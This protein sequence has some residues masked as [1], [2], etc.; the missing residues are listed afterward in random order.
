MLR[1]NGMTSVFLAKGYQGDTLTQRALWRWR[2]RNSWR[3]RCFC[4]PCLLLQVRKQ[5]RSWYHD[6]LYLALQYHDWFIMV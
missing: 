5:L 1:F 3:K 2:L 4:W 6:S